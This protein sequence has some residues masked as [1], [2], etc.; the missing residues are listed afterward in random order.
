MANWLFPVLFAEAPPRVFDTHRDMFL[1][2]DLLLNSP[3]GAQT[4]EMW[5]VA[6]GGV[7]SK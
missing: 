5:N 1:R 4:I 6:I 2:S 3:D 7:H